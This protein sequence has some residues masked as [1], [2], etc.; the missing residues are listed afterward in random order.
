VK[1]PTIVALARMKNGAVSLKCLSLLLYRI[2]CYAPQMPERDNPTA[3][4]QHP[5]DVEVID[6][7]DNRTTKNA[8]IKV[9]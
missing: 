9:K 6:I 1:C 8:K 3:Q 4:S 7:F 2:V 5:L